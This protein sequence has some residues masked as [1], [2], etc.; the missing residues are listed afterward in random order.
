MT[1]PSDKNT[2]IEELKQKV[3]EFCE[4]RDWDQFHNAKEIST[5]LI[6]E[7]AELLEHFRWKSAAEVEEFFKKQDKKDEIADELSDVF[8][9]LLR[10]AQM[11]DIDLA[12]SFEKQQAKAARKYP[13][14]KAKGNNKKYNEI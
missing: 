3:R 12:S 13:V 9:N 10:F 5:A 4:E 6:I 8:F 14:D 2:N 1:L 7:A 11:Y